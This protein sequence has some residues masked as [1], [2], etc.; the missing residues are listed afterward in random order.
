MNKKNKDFIE[1]GLKIVHTIHGSQVIIVVQPPTESEKS[2]SLFKAFKDVDCEFV[3]YVTSV[4]NFYESLAVK[5]KDNLIVAKNF[6]S[7]SKKPFKIEIH[8]K[9]S[10]YYQTLEYENCADFTKSVKALF[11]SGK[12]SFN[13]IGQELDAFGKPYKSSQ[14]TDKK[15]K[16]RVKQNG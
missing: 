6:L 13:L 5:I 10:P 4:D 1:K 2:S 14:S 8:G 11:K 7:P 9:A 3:R 15:I 16:Q 12:I